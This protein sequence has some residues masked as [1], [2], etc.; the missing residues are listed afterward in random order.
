ML[1]TAVADYIVPLFKEITMGKTELDLKKLMTSLSSLQNR[2]ETIRT[3]VVQIDFKSWNQFMRGN[4]LS[5]L[6]RCLGE[7]FGLPNIFN[8]IHEGFEEAFVYL[9]SE[10]FP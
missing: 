9:S 3:E 5:P 4:Q 7:L 6:I 2:S 8:R 10:E 1:E